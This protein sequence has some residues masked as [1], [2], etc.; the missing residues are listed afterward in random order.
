MWKYNNSHLIKLI[1]HFEKLPGI[2]KKSAQKLAYHILKM[3][4]E[5]AES[6]AKSILEAR[7]NIKSCKIC[8]AFTDK[9]IC[10]ICC[11]KSRDISTICVIEDSRDIEIIERTNEFNG[12]YHILHG[13]ISPLNGIGPDDIKINELINRVQS[14]DIKEIIMATNPT[15]EGEATSLYISKILKNFNIKITRLAYGIP[16][17]AT[18]EYA[19]EATLSRALLGRS[20]II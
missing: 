16:L 11:N 4:K 10:N 3:P 20:E 14:S 1:E 18:I 13:V 9:E 8:C 2:G 7:S 17:G 12:V 19:D 5:N 6:F 15:V